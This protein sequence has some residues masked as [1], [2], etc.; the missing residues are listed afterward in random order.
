MMFTDPVVF[1][2]GFA[3][4]FLAGAAFALAYNYHARR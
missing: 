1:V 4:G 3:I 2:I